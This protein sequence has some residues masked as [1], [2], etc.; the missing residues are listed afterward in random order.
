MGLSMLI[1]GI[2]HNIHCAAS[3]FLGRVLEDPLSPLFLPIPSGFPRGWTTLLRTCMTLP[4][5]MLGVFILQPSATVTGNTVMRI[6]RQK[7]MKMQHEFL[8]GLLTCIEGLLAAC[9]CSMLM[10]YRSCMAGQGHVHASSIVLGVLDCIE[11]ARST[12][13]VTRAL[14]HPS[15]E[16]R[17]QT[18]GRVG[19]RG[20]E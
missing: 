15:V 2:L 18:E 3:I 4:V 5:M 14:C 11:P 9:I 20:R 16:Q 7:D 10:T 1:S 19:K 12:K 8:S 13:Y 6:P 17:H